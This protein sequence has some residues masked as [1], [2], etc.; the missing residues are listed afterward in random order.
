MEQ[1]GRV[2]V[3]GAWAEPGGDEAI[4]VISPHTEEPIATVAAAGP[5][6]VE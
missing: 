2:F 1:P 3:G 5:A 6:E 4:E